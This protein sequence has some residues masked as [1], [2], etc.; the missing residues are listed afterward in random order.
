MSKFGSILDPSLNLCKTAQP[1]WTNLGRDGPLDEEIQICTNEVDLSLGGAIWEPKS[2]KKLLL[3]NEQQF[4]LC[5]T[6]ST[7]F[8]QICISSSKGPSLPRL[9]Q[10]GWAVLQRKIKMW[11]VNRQQMPS[12]GKN[13]YGHLRKMHSIFM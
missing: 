3:K 13:S 8:V 1:N 7:S 11:K 6:K 4:L 2:K 5:S 9:V 12:D 10:F